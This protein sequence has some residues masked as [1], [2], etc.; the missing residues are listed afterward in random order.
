MLSQRLDR[1]VRSSELS[2]AEGRVDLFMTDHVKQN[3]RTS[4]TPLKFRDKM[5]EVLRDIRW[6]LAQTQWANRVICGRLGHLLASASM[7][8][9]IHT[10]QKKLDL[11]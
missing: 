9:Y 6:N 3:R 5:M 11:S 1:V 10:L 2:F 7:N 8:L 4:F